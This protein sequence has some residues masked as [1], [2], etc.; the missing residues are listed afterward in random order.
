MTSVIRC[1]IRARY[2]PENDTF[3]NLSVENQTLKRQPRALFHIA[4][5]VVSSSGGGSFLT[6][7]RVSIPRP[8]V[9]FRPIYHVSISIFTD[10]RHTDSVSLSTSIL[11]PFYQH[12]MPFLPIFYGL[13]TDI[14]FHP[15]ICYMSCLP[16]SCALSKNNL[17]PPFPHS[18]PFL[19]TFYVLSTHSLCSF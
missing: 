6:V 7:P 13:S 17:C 9:P 3:G 10:L 8:S 16:T 12:S 18:L 11:C 1:D 19:S 15:P 4:R 14:F 5:S 2:H